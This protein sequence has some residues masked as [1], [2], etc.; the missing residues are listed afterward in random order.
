MAYAANVIRGDDPSTTKL[1]GERTAKTSCQYLL[2]HV[3]KSAKILDVG[4]GPG[5][6]TA[7]LAKIAS[8]GSTIGVDN[9]EGIIKQASTSFPDVPN[10]KYQVGDATNLKDFADNSFDI[11]HAHQLLVHISN[12]VPV[13]KEFYRVCKPGG[14]IAVRESSPSVVLFLKPD[15]P[16]IRQYWDRAMAMM[17]KIG[18][19]T[20]AGIDLEK[21]AKEAFGTDG[22]KL[23]YTKTPVWNAGHTERVTG[24]AAAHAIQYGMATQEEMDQWAEAWKEWD[25]AEDHE[26]V[27]EAGEILCRKGI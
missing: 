9:S 26:W 18:A 7:D 13:L 24:P 22:E 8:D 14:I 2:P 17:P 27:F 3:T 20:Q 4:C 6:I 19:Q 5:I 16:G 21:W 15:L 25:A 12:P 1:Y 23:V 10:L 11:V